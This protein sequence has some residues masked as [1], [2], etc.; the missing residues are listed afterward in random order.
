MTARWTDRD[1]KGTRTI[2]QRAEMVLMRHGKNAVRVQMGRAHRY[3][4]PD[5]MEVANE[6]VRLTRTPRWNHCN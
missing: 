6:I 5:V 1:F 2:Q 3:D 4:N